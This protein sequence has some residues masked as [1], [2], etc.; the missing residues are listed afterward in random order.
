MTYVLWYGNW[1]LLGMIAPIVI[2]YVGVSVLVTM[3]AFGRRISFGGAFLTSLFLSPVVG[4]IAI[5]K[6]DKNIKVN[7][8]AT[9]YVCPKCN[10]EYTEPKLYCS[11]CKE[12]GHNVKL[13]PKRMLIK[14]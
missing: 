11:L 8:Y 12:M 7:Y 10:F 3:L 5:L 14:E 1:N 6:S 4:L 2:L 9:R 13:E